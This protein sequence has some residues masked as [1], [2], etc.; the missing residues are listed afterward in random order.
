[1]AA[2]LGDVRRDRRQLRDLMP[3]RIPDRMPGVQAAR[4]VATRRRREIHDRIHT[5]H[6]D[7]L[8]M[9]PRMARLP[10]GFASTLHAPAPLPL[11]TREAI[12]RRRF[13]GDGGILLSKRELAFEFGDPFRLVGIFLAKPL[14]LPTQPLDVRRISARR[15][16]RLRRRWLGIVPLSASPLHAR[17]RT[18]LRCQVQEACTVT[19]VLMK[20]NPSATAALHSGE[21]HV[22]ACGAVH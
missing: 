13:R 21:W 9:V 11:P 22:D 1:M 18:E 10:A 8:P 6:G 4:A 16:G 12:G 14:I 20:V 17:E 19:I 3:T 5:F 7:Q 15:R 2:K